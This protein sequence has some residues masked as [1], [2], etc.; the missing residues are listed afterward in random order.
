MTWVEYGNRIA[1]GAKKELLHEAIRERMAKKHGKEVEA[2]A[3]AV[4]KISEGDSKHE[5]EVE[6]RLEKLFGEEEE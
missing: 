6:E 3:E 2:I 4:I 1:Y 5:N